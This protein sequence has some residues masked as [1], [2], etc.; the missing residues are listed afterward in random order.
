MTNGHL[1]VMWKAPYCSFPI[2]RSSLHETSSSLAHVTVAPFASILEGTNSNSSWNKWNPIYPYTADCLNNI[3]ARFESVSESSW[4][5]H[6]GQEQQVVLPLD[7]ILS[8]FGVSLVSF[9]AIT[10]CTAS[11]WVLTVVCD[12]SDCNDWLERTKHLLETPGNCVR[13]I[14]NI[15]TALGDSNMGRMQT[16]V[17]FSHFR[18]GLRLWAQQC[19]CVCVCVWESCLQTCMTYTIAECTVSKLLMMDRRTVRNM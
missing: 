10:L 3:T 16:F 6:E 14:P 2:M 15:K 19:V 1:T 5:Y 7:A 18:C 12:L 17:W 9:A 13:N 4:T 11:H 8:V